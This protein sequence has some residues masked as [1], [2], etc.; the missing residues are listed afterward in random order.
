MNNYFS[1]LEQDKKEDHVLFKNNIENF[2][3]FII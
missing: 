2:K 3:Y 1:V